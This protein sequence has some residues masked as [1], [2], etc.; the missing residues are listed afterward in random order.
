MSVISNEAANLAIGNIARYGDTDIFPFPIENRM[1]FDNAGEVKK[2]LLEIDGDFQKA[3]A[4][5]P[6]VKSNNLS[7]VGYGG[8]RWG[9]QIDPVWNAYLLALTLTIA[10]DLE[11]CRVPST[12]VFSYR[13]KPDLTTFS[14][15]SKDIGW[16]QFQEKSIDEARSHEY[17]M[18]CDISDFYPRIYHHRL[19]NALKSA[20]KNQEAVKRIMEILG[21]LSDGASYGLPVGGPAS[22]ILSEILL[23]RIDKLLTLEQ[24]K[25]GRFVDDF[26]VFANSREEAYSAL[27]RLSGLLLNNEGLSL[28][29]AKTRVMTSEEFLGT[30][31]FT[32]EAKLES[33]NDENER[34][35][36]KLR[37]HYDP[38]STTA[39]ADY[40]K[41]LAELNN[42]D[43]VGMLGRQLIKSRV[44]EGLTRRL[45]AALK[46]LSVNVQ[47]DAVLS[48]SR[49]F[50]LL[51]PIFPSVMNLCRG[52]LDVLD[53]KVK[54]ELYKSLRQLIQ[55]NS[56]V[57][58]VP[59]NL[60][61]ALR[62]LSTDRSEDTEILL[63][64]IFKQTDS[65]MLRRDI[66][67]MMA[68]RRADHWISN[69]RK[70]F[71][72]MNQWERRA[73][74]ISSYT[75]GDEGCHW[76]DAIK[77]DLNSFDKLVLKWTGE[78]KAKKGDDWRVPI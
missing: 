7:A 66:I 5:I 33:D 15:F 26:V 69:C 16:L 75:L 49:N 30:S 28:Q 67:L 3:I 50:D 35:F 71:S 17:M 11:V 6:I 77:K 73:L 20:T 36:R 12:V 25:Y 43:I 72:T 19:E 52:L 59:T 57:T 2:I 54:S 68:Y 56:Y 55:K 60:A 38:Y 34:S 18:R 58:Q 76:R 63:A 51:Y 44:D 42:F 10:N 23:N 61:F 9:A 78:S 62:T 1:F 65:I 48:L 22:R 40:E 37:V 53:E 24:V 70:S 39:N 31:D 14:L 13:F 29:K 46:H 21:E 64:N 4:D 8:F 32:T 27:I 47:N 45:I 74:L 41:L